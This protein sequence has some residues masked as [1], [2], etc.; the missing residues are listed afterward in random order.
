MT[1]SPPLLLDEDAEGQRGH[2]SVFI[3]VLLGRGNLIPN[4]ICIPQ[5]R[6]GFQP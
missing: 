6:R 4:S 1:N 3:V 2:L 5:P